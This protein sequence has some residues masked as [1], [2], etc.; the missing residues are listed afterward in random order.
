MVLAILCAYLLGSIPSGYLL[1]K[2]WKGIDIRQYGSGNIGTTNVWRTLGPAAGII[3]LIMDAGKGWLAVYIA[4][5][6]GGNGVQLAAALG[7]MAGHSWPLF[8]RFKGG[9][10]IATAAGAVLN[11]AP[12]PT[13][14][15]LVIWL[16]TLGLT[17]Y[18][19][20][21]SI[22]AAVTVPIAMYALHF[23]RL[24]LGFGLVV[25]GFAVYK[26]IP[27]IKRLISGTEFKVGQKKS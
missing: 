10:I 14:I 23:D 6:L 7:A 24:F 16:V 15:A 21:S 25:A 5:H 13:L 27:N 22:L 17:R 19:S 11:L 4:R 2:Y 26:H 1:A 12:V 8:L 3:V 9:K 18:V 20:L